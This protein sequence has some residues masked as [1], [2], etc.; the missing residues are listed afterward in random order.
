MTADQNRWQGDLM[1]MHPMM[2]YQ[3]QFQIHNMLKY[4]VTTSSF[5]FRKLSLKIP[6]NLPFLGLSY[7]SLNNNAILL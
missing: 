1:S 6:R 3:K 7:C 2:I 5:S 4:N